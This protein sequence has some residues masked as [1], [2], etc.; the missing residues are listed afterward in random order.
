ML[1][2][3]AVIHSEPTNVGNGRRP[4]FDERRDCVKLIDDSIGA[5]E[6]V[7]SLVTSNWVIESELLARLIEGRQRSAEAAVELTV[8][9]LAAFDAKADGS[10]NRHGHF[11][12]V[13]SQLS[14]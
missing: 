3:D 11:E 13:V 6:V 4:C 14:G 5:D 12:D 8:R 10:A 1:S 9:L 7:R 2:H